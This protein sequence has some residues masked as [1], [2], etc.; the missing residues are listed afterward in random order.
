MDAEE[1]NK[2]YVSDDL[3]DNKRFNLFTINGYLNNTKNPFVVKT[4]NNTK[5]DKDDLLNNE[6]ITKE[7]YENLL[8]KN[9]GID[10]KKENNK[11]EE[12]N[13]DLQVLNNNFIILINKYND[14]VYNIYNGIKI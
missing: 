11:N 6:F 12:N 4:T 9:K 2:D 1:S 10:F 7:E 8:D 3:I 5:F 14:K 13:T